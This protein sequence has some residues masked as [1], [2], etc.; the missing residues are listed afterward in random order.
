MQQSTPLARLCLKLQ[1]RTLDMPK[2]SR[3]AT[4]DNRPDPDLVAEAL[5]QYLASED[6]QN[7]LADNP[8]QVIIL[9]V[10]GQL[11]LVQPDLYQPHI[12]NAWHLDLDNPQGIVKQLQ[13]SHWKPT[14]YQYSCNHC[15]LL[16]SQDKA[17]PSV[18]CPFCGYTETNENYPAWQRLMEIM[19]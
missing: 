2:H 15:H 11:V 1:K 3:K 18:I 12:F 19:Q 6:P 10:K 5:N 4:S 9:G 16:T 14:N 8:G 7:R 13:S 17:S